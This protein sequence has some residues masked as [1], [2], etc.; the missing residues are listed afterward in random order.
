MDSVC[1]KTIS[2]CE[3]DDFTDGDKFKLL[4]PG[5]IARNLNF[6]FISPK[7]LSLLLHENIWSLIITNDLNLFNIKQHAYIY[8]HIHTDAHTQS[9]ST[10]HMSLVQTQT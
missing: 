1:F 9:P 6:L 3:N 7:Y 4:T 8:A 5:L 10:H 2:F